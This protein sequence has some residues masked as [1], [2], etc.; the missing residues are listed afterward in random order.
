VERTGSASGESGGGLL[1]KRVTEGLRGSGFLVRGTGAEVQI[2]VQ[3]SSTSTDGVRG[4]EVHGARSRAEV[5]AVGARGEQRLATGSAVTVGFGAT[6][7]GA[8]QMAARRALEQALTPVLRVLEQ[9][10][11]MG[12]GQR[13]SWSVWISGIDSSARFREVR[14]TLAERVTIIRRVRPRQVTVSA[15]G[16]LVETAPDLGAGDVA[17]ALTR[18]VYPGFSLRV[19]R[20]EG[21]AIWLQLTTHSDSEL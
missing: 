18:H 14:R 7:T 1:R 5:R 9:R 3:I 8:R 12:R 19:E 21:G 4:L 15:A 2:L 13:G 17:S 6:V 20:I 11:P 10:Y 16:F